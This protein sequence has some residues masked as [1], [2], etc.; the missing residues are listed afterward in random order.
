MEDLLKKFL[1]DCNTIFL[2]KEERQLR[3]RILAKVLLE[4]DVAYTELA[5]LKP[6]ITQLID[7]LG[8]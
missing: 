8:L 2:S 7:Y 6:E 1:Q 4:I 3:A 5:H